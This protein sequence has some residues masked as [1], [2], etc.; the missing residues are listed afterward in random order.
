MIVALV[1]TVTA[2]LEMTKVLVRMNAE[3]VTPRAKSKRLILEILAPFNDRE[4]VA[5]APN[6]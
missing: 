2:R 4:F 3:N 1:C 6:L 5:H